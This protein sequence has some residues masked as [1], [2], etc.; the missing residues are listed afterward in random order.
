M[1][2]R[3]SWSLRL[4]V[5]ACL[6]ALASWP[7]AQ[8]RTPHR[9]AQEEP[10]Y[11][12]DPSHA[13]E[14]ALGGDGLLFGYRSG[15][16]RGDGDYSV[17]V[18]AGEDDDY[19]LAVRLM[20]F[21]EPSVES[22]LGFGIGLG[23]FGALVDDTDD[24]VVAITLTGA[25]DLALEQVFVLEYPARIGVEASFA[26][27]AATF[28]DGERVLEVQGRFEVDLSSWASFFAGYRHLELDVD[29][30]DPELDR[31]LHAGVRLGF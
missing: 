15:L 16:H 17:G 14:F 7:T 6:G 1:V 5:P 25:V 10:L 9:P 22:P 21:G 3:S 23:V 26:P 19:A 18:F 20:R 13:L 30:A 4:A 2:Q 31:A 11:V 24:E 8:E 28:A 29:G 27:D 12:P